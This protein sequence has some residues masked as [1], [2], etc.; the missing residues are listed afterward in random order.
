[1]SFTFSVTKKFN[2]TDNKARLGLL[3]TSHGKIETPAF[4]PVGTQGTIKGILPKEM[5]DLGFSIILSNAYHLFLRP[6]H[7]LIQQEGYIALWD[8]IGRY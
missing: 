5:E 2:N 3:E 8:G 4:M 6:G 1:M 7:Q